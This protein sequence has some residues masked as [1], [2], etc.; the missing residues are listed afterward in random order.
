MKGCFCPFVASDTYFTIDWEKRFLINKLWIPFILNLKK[1]TN[2][3]SIR[4]RTH[5]NVRKQGNNKNHFLSV[6]C[7]SETVFIISTCTAF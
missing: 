5:C 7:V 3:Q 6:Y 1:Q 2:M 4:V